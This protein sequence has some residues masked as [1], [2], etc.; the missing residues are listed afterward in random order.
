LF[1]CRISS[2]EGKSSKGK[3]TARRYLER[4]R[5]K[6]VIGELGVQELE[7]VLMVACE[8]IFDPFFDATKLTQYPSRLSLGFLFR[9]RVRSFRT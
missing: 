8:S 4:A 7:S 3:E 1:F 5:T 2:A 9:V 6:S